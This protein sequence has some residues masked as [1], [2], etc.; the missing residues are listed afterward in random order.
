VAPHA[1]YDGAV[2]E[3]ARIGI[4]CCFCD[5]DEARDG[6]CD[7]YGAEGKDQSETEFLSS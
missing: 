2:G 5:L 6:E 4:R 7:D 3:G 1:Q